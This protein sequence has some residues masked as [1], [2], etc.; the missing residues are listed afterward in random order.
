M[1]FL[2]ALQKAAYL[3]KYNS[4]NVMNFS[5]KTPRKV[6]SLALSCLMKK[7]KVW[8]DVGKISRDN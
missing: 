4:K 5:L 7:L 2:E 8:L 6:H 3:S 1:K